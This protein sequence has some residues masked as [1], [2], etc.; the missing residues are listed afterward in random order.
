LPCVKGL[1]WRPIV[2]RKIPSK[3]VSSN[4]HV[5]VGQLKI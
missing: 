3:T 2:V 4:Q 5:L 1:A